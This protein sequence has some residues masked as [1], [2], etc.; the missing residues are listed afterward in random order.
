M[1]KKRLSPVETQE[2]NDIQGTAHSY[3]RFVGT[4]NGEESTRA[5]PDLLA[6]KQPSY[7]STPQMI[8]GEAIEHLQGRQKEVYFRVM[9]EDL[10]LA[11]AAESLGITKSTVQV[12][13]DRAIAFISQYCKA[14][15]D[16]ERV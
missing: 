8:M 7:P 9:R 13:L 11:E 4:H 15:V 14:A 16:R 2:L 5:N 12:Y 3:E 1:K 6:D 10:S